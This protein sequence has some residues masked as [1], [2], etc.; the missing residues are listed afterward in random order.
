MVKVFAPAVASLGIL[1]LAQIFIES[2]A[3][4]KS[5]ASQIPKVTF[6]FCCKMFS[7]PLVKAFAE[8]QPPSSFSEKRATAA[9][10]VRGHP[11]GEGTPQKSCS[12]SC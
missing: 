11:L 10:D 1:N 6:W 9:L 8:H 4:E 5:R 2:E 3:S 7:N 12:A